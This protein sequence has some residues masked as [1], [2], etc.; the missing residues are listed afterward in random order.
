MRVFDELSQ[1]VH[2]VGP[3]IPWALDS[4][5]LSLRNYAVLGVVTITITS[6]FQLEGVVVSEVLT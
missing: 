4:T 5:G 1:R 6:E 2:G 3:W